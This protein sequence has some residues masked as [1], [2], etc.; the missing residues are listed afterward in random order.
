MSGAI[1]SELMNK[2]VVD[3]LIE[4]FLTQDKKVVCR[5][6]ANAMIDYNRLYFIDSL[7]TSE[8]SSLTYRI[9]QN[10]IEVRKFAENGPDGDLT[11]IIIEHDK[12]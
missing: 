3:N 11:P 8:L 10:S 2:E 5:L 1:M 6:L 4:Y 7:S 9:E 12:F